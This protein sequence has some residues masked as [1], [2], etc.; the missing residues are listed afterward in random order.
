MQV[1]ILDQLQEPVMMVHLYQA[2]IFYNPKGFHWQ[3]YLPKQ[4]WFLLLNYLPP[5]NFFTN[6]NWEHSARGKGNRVF[7]P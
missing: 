7:K 4:R 1:K 6:E 3:T 2:K 5:S